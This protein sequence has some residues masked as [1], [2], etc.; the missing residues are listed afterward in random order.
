M[1]WEHP[2]APV[3]TYSRFVVCNNGYTIERFIHGWDEKYND[4]QPWHF[5][6]IPTAFG[7]TNYKGYQVKTRDE[8]TKL[9]ADE[10]F[11][12]APHLQVSDECCDVDA[13][14]LY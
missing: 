14:Y 5:K 2:G 9:F 13:T 8:L 10:T 3:L 12:S 4:I 6:D 11:S 1:H 7:A